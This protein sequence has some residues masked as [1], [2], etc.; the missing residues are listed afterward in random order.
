MMKPDCRFEN[1]AVT[2]YLLVTTCFSQFYYFFKAVAQT[3]IFKY[4][5]VIVLYG[6]AYPQS[7]KDEVCNYSPTSLTSIPYKT[8]EQAVLHQLITLET[9]S[10]IANNMS[11]EEA[12]HVKHN[13]ARLAMTLQN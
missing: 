3:N 11:S 4:I 13:C 9:K 8:K 7:L 6:N 1:L 2:I 5:V 10:C 12:G